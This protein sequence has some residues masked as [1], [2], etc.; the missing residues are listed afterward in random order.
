MKGMTLERIAAA[1]DGRLYI[2]DSLNKGNI[3][4][5]E[6]V[7]DSRKITENAVF[8]ATKGNTTDGHKFIGDVVKKGALCVI[9]E[10]KPDNDDGNYIV[11]NDSFV[12]LK[13][14]AKYYKRQLSVRTIGIIGSVGKTSTKE[15]VSSVLSVKYRVK[16]T[17]GNY[18]NE[19][20]V[21]LTVFSIRDEDEIAVIEM[22]ISDF[23]E[24][25][26]LAD[27]V[28]PD[29]CVMTNIG[30]CHLEKLIDLEGV[31]KA[32]AEV[33]EHMPEDGVLILNGDDKKL[34]EIE[35]TKTI[36]YYGMNAAN[37]IY[38]TDIV[39]MGL[40]GTQ[41]TIHTNKGSME[42][43]IPLI[44]EH[45]VINAL[46]ATAAGQLMNMN[47][48]DIKTGL[49]EMVPTRGRANVIKTPEITI[50]DD[51]YNANPKSMKA[52]IDLLLS[53]EGRKVLIIGDMFEL[54]INEEEL[55]KEIG[56]YI[57]NKGID[58]VITAGDL[59]VH[60]YEEVKKD[61]V[62]DSYYCETTDK[63]IELLDKCI[64]RKDDT[65]LVKAS[66]G[67][68]FDRVVEALRD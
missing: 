23:G 7:I 11:V 34:R 47:L 35:K 58:V 1:V 53:V 39:N 18:N 43:H 2:S 27:I 55:H 24:M 61:E 37:D 31:L 28:R 19:V 54:G 38:A 44:G 29:I 66:H 14:L 64:I 33:I 63:V 59:S 62:V 57:C 60:V 67:M 32:K 10:N 42:V 6:V 46:S 41:C 48:S 50:V 4:A 45:M 16:K 20:G 22:G 3:E 8:I 30:P 12:A 52:A 40:N 5:T 36:I 49:E 13:M 15:M 51:C 26:R 9:C 17:Q 21:P 25:H 65:V 68:A 56:E